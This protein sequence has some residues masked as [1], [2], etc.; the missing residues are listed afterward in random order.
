MNKKLSSVSYSL[1]CVL[2]VLLVYLRGCVDCTFYC[3]YIESGQH[4]AG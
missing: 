4:A 2:N 1:I 3:M